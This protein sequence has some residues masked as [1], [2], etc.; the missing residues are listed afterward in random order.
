ML[1][2]L[3]TVLSTESENPT[4]LCVRSEREQD[5]LNRYGKNWNRAKLPLSTREKIA[6]GVEQAVRQGWLHDSVTRAAYR[7][8][9]A[10]LTDADWI[11]HNEATR[12]FVKNRGIDWIFYTT[13][14]TM[15]FETGIPYV[16][17]VFDLQHRLQPDFEEVSACGQW[18]RREYLYRNGIRHATLILADSEVGKEDILNIYGSYGI[19]EEDVKVSPCMPAPYLSPEVSAEER[20]RIRNRY[21]LPEHYFFYPAQFWPH[22]NH[23]RMVQALGLLKAEK[24]MEVHLVLAGTHNGTIRARVFREM[25]QEAHRLR[26]AEQ[27]HYLGYVPNEAMS[28]LYSGAVGLAMPTFFGPT[29]IPIVEAWLFGCPVLTSDIRGIR[30]QVGDAGLLVDPRSVEAIADGMQRLWDHE[31]LRANLAQRGTRRL[32]AHTQ[33]QFCT[34]LGHIIAETNLRIGERMP[35]RERVLVSA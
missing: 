26:V 27:V 2:A 3:S 34:K 24:R 12:R 28:A 29:N 5:A 16:M 8:L 17:P 35:S 6:N 19:S 32:A 13:P 14:S 31:G 21:A 11:W 20:V 7:W 9:P 10:G 15:S 23:V 22:K 25:M 30:D 1:D 4:T 33:G 18:N